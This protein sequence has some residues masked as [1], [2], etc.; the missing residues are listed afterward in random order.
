VMDVILME[1]G[2]FSG[3]GVERFVWLW[4]PRVSVGIYGSGVMISGC[5]VLGFLD[6]L[7]RSCR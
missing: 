1:S 5:T 2:M 3:A 6:L 7:P 4:E